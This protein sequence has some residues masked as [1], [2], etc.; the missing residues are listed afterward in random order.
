MEAPSAA[1]GGARSGDIVALRPLTFYGVVGKR[2][3]ANGAAA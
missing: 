3:A 2:L 1:L